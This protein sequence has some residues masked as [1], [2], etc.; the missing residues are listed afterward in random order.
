[1][2]YTAHMDAG[3]RCQICGSQNL[4]F[5]LNTESDGYVLMEIDCLDCGNHN[6]SDCEVSDSQP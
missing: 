6:A 3:P 4:Q 2:L 1:M 5:R